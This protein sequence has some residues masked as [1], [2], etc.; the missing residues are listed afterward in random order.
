M[1]KILI[2]GANGFVGSHL[3]DEGVRRGYQIYAGVKSTSD[4]R[5]IKKHDFK[6]FPLNLH[7]P[8]NIQ[9]N[10]RKFKEKGIQFEYVIHCA[11]ITKPKKIDEFYSGNSEFTRTF[12]TAL[13]EEHPEFKKFIYISSM[14]AQGPGDGKSFKPVTEL[15]K[16]NP[17]T[18]YGE[19][20][21]QA[22]LY[23]REIQD[24][25]YLVFRPMA[26]YGPR[27][28]KFMLRLIAM[29]NK[30]FEVSLG[31]AKARS[32]VVYVSDLTKLMFDGLE[33]DV[34]RES[35]NISDGHYYPQIQINRTLR[36]ELGVKTLSIRI[37]RW[38]L[39]SV[40]YAFYY[41][42]KFIQ[43]PLHLSPFK[44]KELTALNWSVD[45]SK[46]KKMLD[47]YPQYTLEQGVK[48]TVNWYRNSGDSSEPKT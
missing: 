1:K 36:K 23:L 48:E 39:L 18:P 19:S 47:F 42:N 29:M 24:L 13:K 43:K 20:K 5:F 2:T 45:I 21:R 33:S 30:G 8:Q 16:P 40:S 37:P 15:Q 27:D 6:T 34:S 12:A 10:L 31:S 7:K 41:G 26:V 46:A 32:A 22:E 44:I 38:F 35:F 3:V 25:D 11:A 9:K 4:L 14:S 28:R 17:F